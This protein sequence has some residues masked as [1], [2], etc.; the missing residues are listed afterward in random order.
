MTV[1]VIELPIRDRV[2][3]TFESVALELVHNDSET[4]TGVKLLA[5]VL[6][7]LGRRREILAVMESNSHRRAAADLILGLDWFH[8]VRD[9]APD[10]VV[11]LTRGGPLDFRTIGSGFYCHHPQVPRR[12]SEETSVRR[13]PRQC[14]WVDLVHPDASYAR[15]QAISYARWNVPYAGRSKLR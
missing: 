2:D 11:Y 4:R 12:C 10:L 13:P 15:T 6:A 1:A 5:S 8:F 3:I 14:P 7:R 9:S